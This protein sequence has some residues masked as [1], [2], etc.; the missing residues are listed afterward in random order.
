[1]NIKRTETE[2]IQGKLLTDRPPKIL[3]IT[4]P[5]QLMNR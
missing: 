5:N 2:A 4:N 3:N 1:M